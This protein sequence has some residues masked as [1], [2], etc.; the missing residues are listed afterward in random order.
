MPGSVRLNGQPI[1]PDSKVRVTVNSFLASGGDNFAVL[2]QGTERRT[3]MMDIDAFEAY[4]KAN[5]TLSPGPLD[6]VTRLN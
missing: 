2:R 1:T 4:V 5:P 6:R 3:G